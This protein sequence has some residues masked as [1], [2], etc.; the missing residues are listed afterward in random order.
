MKSE[1][2]GMGADGWE[3]SPDFTA[4]YAISSAGRLVPT[5]DEFDARHYAPPLVLPW[6]ACIYSCSYWKP[7]TFYAPSTPCI[8]DNCAPNKNDPK[9]Y[10]ATSVGAINPVSAHIHTVW[11]LRSHTLW[12]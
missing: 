8:Y 3:S 6:F 2:W 9:S 7:E 11:C 4:A 12:F 5:S 1:E 10:P